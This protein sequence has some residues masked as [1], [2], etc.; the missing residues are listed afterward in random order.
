M[1]AKARDDKAFLHKETIENQRRF[2]GDELLRSPPIDEGRGGLIE[3]KATNASIQ[4][5][6]TNSTKP[7]PDNSGFWKGF[8]N[9]LS[10][11][12]F[13]EFGDRVCYSF[14]NNG[15]RLS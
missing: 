11:I 5:Q 13:V 2:L 12:F 1:N 3:A 8:V 6:T 7:K 4:N 10:M 15:F 9:S 14:N